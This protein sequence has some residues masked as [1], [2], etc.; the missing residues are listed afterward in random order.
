MGYTYRHTDWWE[1]FMKY[2]VEMDSGAMIYIPSFIKTGTGI[3]NL[4][5]GIQRHIDSKMIS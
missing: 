1:G 4:I 3:Q 2:D 5:G